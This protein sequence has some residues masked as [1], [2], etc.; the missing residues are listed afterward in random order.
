VLSYKEESNF[1]FYKLKGKGEDSIVIKGAKGATRQ[2]GLKL[3]KQDFYPNLQKQNGQEGK[4]V[5]KMLKGKK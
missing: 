5:E 4:Q 2:K 1:V 3:Y